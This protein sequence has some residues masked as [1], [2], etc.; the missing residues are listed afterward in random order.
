ML[1]VYVTL[2]CGPQA[3]I[4]GFHFPRSLLSVSGK[5][6]VTPRILHRASSFLWKAAASTLGTGDVLGQRMGAKRPW[7]TFAAQGIDLA[8]WLEQL[9]AVREHCFKS[10]PAFE[11]SQKRHQ[12][13]CT[14]T[15]FEWNFR[16][17]IL[18]V[19]DSWLVNWKW[20]TFFNEEETRN[21]KGY[22]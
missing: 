4:P 5:E 6:G 20:V 19:T 15:N 8:H 12:D 14:L 11:G 2:C 9:W 1:G 16:M 18:C 7:E 17:C 22:F 21:M 13:R 10:V 3:H